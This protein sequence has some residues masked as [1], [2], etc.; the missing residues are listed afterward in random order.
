VKTPLLITLGIFSFFCEMPVWANAKYSCDRDFY[1][2]SSV[3]RDRTSSW[4]IVSVRHRTGEGW[5][6]D[7]MR[8][9]YGGGPQYHQGFGSTDACG[10]AQ[11]NAT[12]LA[13]R[14][15]REYHPRSTC[16]QQEAVPLSDDGYVCKVQVTVE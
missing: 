8:P 10:E 5:E 16:N 9:F 11:R 12:V 1:A 2:S 13:Q 3:C 6:F 4:A 7:P 15:C 14:D